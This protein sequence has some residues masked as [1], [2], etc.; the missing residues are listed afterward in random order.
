M[1]H[2]KPTS[3]ARDLLG[4]MAQTPRATFRQ[5]LAIVRFP[6]NPAR[7]KIHVQRLLNALVDDGFAAFDGRHYAITE[8]GAEALAAL[9]AGRDVFSPAR[10]SL[11]VWRPAA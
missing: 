10:P 1:S 7:R 9:R 3:R 4:H 6:A 11:R 8:D 5:L 2:Y